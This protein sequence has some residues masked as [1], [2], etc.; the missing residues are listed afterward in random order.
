MAPPTGVKVKICGQ[1]SADDCRMSLDAGADYLGVVFEVEASP[2]SLDF[3]R[4][5]PIFDAF[6][7]RTFLL[8]LN[9][10]A[11][12][13]LVETI[14]R[15]NPLALQL[16]GQEP[17]ETVAQ[18]K[19]RTGAPVYKSIHLPPKGIGD[20][21]D[22]DAMVATLKRYADA[23]ADGFVLD[24]AARGLFGGTGVQSDWS[25]ATALVARA[26][27]PVFIAGGINPD[28]VAEAAAIPGVFGVDM[29]SGVES[30]KGIKSRDKLAQLFARLGRRG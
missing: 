2:R 19:A 26:P 16:T 15:L 25:V 3:D 18:M 9:R 28:N 10:T 24:T 7:S 22:L 14:A 8:T 17:P 23:G 6:R 1:T 13:P 21:P 11:D 27:G 30:G 5:A 12:D 29:A 4:A 20:E